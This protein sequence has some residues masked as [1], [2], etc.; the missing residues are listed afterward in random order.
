MR[1]HFWGQTQNVRSGVLR[2]PYFTRLLKKETLT[3]G[4]ESALPRFRASGL[5][6]H[7]NLK[8]ESS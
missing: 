5:T 7:D 4:G 6:G 3:L 8:D 1:K 2:A